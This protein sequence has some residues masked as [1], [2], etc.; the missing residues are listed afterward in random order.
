MN[1]RKLTGLL[2][3]LCVLLCALVLLCACGGDK[4]PTD[5]DAETTGA[6]TPITTDPDT[7]EETDPEVTQSQETETPVDSKVTYTITVVDQDGNPVADVEV[8]MCNVDGICL[9]P[10]V[11]NDSGIATFEQN[12]AVYYVTIPSCP[13]GYTADKEEKH[14]FAE[15][16]KE[17]T[18]TIQ[19][20]AEETS[21][22][23]TEPEV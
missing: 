12:E 23:T 9:L 16:S 10:T 21:E 1:K 2:S 11:T 15:G 5:T 4:T 14:N 7:N 22:E 17:M 19:K 20:D 6:E 3:V 13:E 8:Q 18:V